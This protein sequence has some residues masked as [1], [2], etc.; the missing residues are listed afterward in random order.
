MRN[1]FSPELFF[2][3]SQFEYSGIFQ[4]EDYVWNIIKKIPS[5]MAFLFE[6]KLKGNYAAN[7]WIGKDVKLDPTARIEGP[8]IILDNASI[9]FNALVRGNVI[10][11]KNAIVGHA[12]EVKNS[13]L[14]SASKAAHFNYVSDSILGNEVRLGVG[15]VIVNKR[16]DRGLVTIKVNEH[17]R[18]DT[19]LKKFGSII[20][21]RTRVGANAVINPGTII[22]KNA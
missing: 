10:I 16:V 9:G 14:L 11:D 12:S 13:I 8:A 20:G 17:E 19:Q 7:I 18:I 6:G 15:S 4:K 2:N 1:S 21:D 3:L 5:Y 22:G